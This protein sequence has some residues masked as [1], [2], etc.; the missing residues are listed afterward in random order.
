M[1]WDQTESRSYKVRKKLDHPVVDGDGHT[2]EYHPL[3]V[4]YLR[5]VGGNDLTE[6][7]LKQRMTGANWHRLSA[8]ERYDRRA[9]RPPFWTMPAKN[10]LD[11]ATAMMPNLFRARMDELGIDFA[12][13]YTS[14]LHFMR[15]RDPELRRAACRAVN[16][17]NADRFREHATRMTPA[18][19]IPLGTPEEGIDELTFAVKELGCKAIQ[20]TGLMFRPVPAVEREAPQ[21]AK[22][23]LWIDPLALDSAFNYDPFWA[24]CVELKVAPT[25]H[26]SGMGWGSRQNIRNYTYNHIGHF[27]AAGEASCK[28]LFLGGVTR[29]FPALR[30]GFLEGGTSWAVS[31]YND[32]IEHWE[33]RNI[34]TLMANLDPINVDRAMLQ[35]LAREYGGAE[36]APYIDALAKSHKSTGARP[37]LVPE[38]SENLDDWSACGIEK[39]EDIHDLFVPRFFFGCE[40]DDRTTSMAFNR[41]INHFGARLN[42]IFSSDV[43][44]WD[45]PDMRDT[46]AEAH[47]LVEEGLM[48]DGDFRDFTF[49]N[50]VR[51]HGGVNPDFFK[52]TAVE[53]DAAKVLQQRIRS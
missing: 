19:L 33:K 3:V 45:V 23:A 14:Q 20:I 44:H 8:E 2:Q 36:Y 48:D 17:L 5:K 43:S 11:L 18:A 4:E 41:K 34:K 15:E 26:S 28:A 7:Y 1:P 6:R 52:G 29:R 42:A 22:N 25:T 39:A 32:L 49:A 38:H 47:E 51:L 50:L 10:T 30:F 35:R 9:Y 37:G 24:K 21:F 40:A 13:V 46:L 27:A 12:V 31:L 53:S 16:M